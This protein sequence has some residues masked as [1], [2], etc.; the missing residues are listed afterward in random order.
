MVI[1]RVRLF[2]QVPLERGKRVNQ[3]YCNK[4]QK[5][6]PTTAVEH[7]GRIFLDKN[8]PE[9]GLTQTLISSSA[10]RYWQKRNLDPGYD[11]RS[12]QLTCLQ[13]QHAKQPN[14]VFIDITNRCNLNC[15]ICINNTP[16][17]GYLFEPPF[18]YF[19]KIFQQLTTLDPKPSVQLFGGEPTVRDDLLEI[20]ACA[21]SHGL[22]VRIVTNGIKLANKE[23]CDELVASRATILIAYD[24]AKPE[25]YEVLRGSG[26]MLAKKQQALANLDATGKAKVT[27]MTLIARDFNDDEMPALFEMAH[28]RRNVIRAIYFMPLAHT[29]DSESFD[30]TPERTT[31]EDI[32]EMVAKVYPDDQVEF[33]PAGLLGQLTALLACLQT[34]TVPFMG[35]HPNCESM[36]LL[37]SDG[38]HYV[39]LSQF[40][41][42]SVTA[43]AADF[44]ALDQRLARLLAKHP[45]PSA[46]RRKWFLV[47]AVL[48][49]ARLLL[50]HSRGSRLL[51]GQ[52]VLSRGC[53]GLAT[54]GGFLMGRKSHATLARHTNVSNIL[55]LIVLP[56]EDRENLETERLERC[57]ASFAFY[58]PHADQVRHVPVCAWGL[59]KNEV[60]KR[61]ADHYAA[62]QG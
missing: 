57:P 1:V 33:L 36:Y 55:Q 22:A 60:M 27:L 59:H 30:L 35:A 40:L 53:H 46:W 18:A 34:K 12:C 38:Q 15:P 20:I 56:F 23:Y 42:Y 29:W 4:C 6:V 58:D 13:C 61:I 21:R 17:M 37:V 14:I 47:R 51:R 49:V 26:K 52:G 48:G 3:S 9:C 45:G 43:A 10:G 50:K 39:P 31:T 41:R 16:S 62:G 8:C 25:T 28:E 5:L 19:E 11:Y 54:L 7:E 44:V 32:E 2:F 24:G